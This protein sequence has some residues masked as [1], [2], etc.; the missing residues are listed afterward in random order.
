MKDINIEIDRLIKDA[1]RLALGEVERIVRK[2][3]DSN[4][5]LFSFQMCMGSYFFNDKND[6]ILHNYECEELDNFIAE[7]DDILKITGEPMLLEKSGGYILKR[8]EW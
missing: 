8:T 7:W 6:E 3:L 5:D 4:D 2:E 1:D